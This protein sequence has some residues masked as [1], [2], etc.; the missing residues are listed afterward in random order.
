MGQFDKLTHDKLDILAA[1]QSSNSP[2]SVFG[3]VLVVQPTTVF[4][5][6]FIDTKLLHG[7]IERSSL[8]GTVT[9]LDQMV[10][11]NT[12]IT[13][14]ATAS[15]RAEKFLR[16]NPGKGSGWKGT[17]I[18][19]AGIANSLQYAGLATD[20]AAFIIGY[21]GTKFGIARQTAGRLEI[22]A[23]QITTKS[24]TAE[25]ITVTLDSVAFSVPVT[26]QTAGTASH[27]AAEIAEFNAYPGWVCTAVD[28]TIYFVKVI[29]GV[30]SGTYSLSG[31]T[32]AVG[33][34]TQ[35][36]A[37]A[38]TVYDWFYMENFIIE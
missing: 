12:G 35:N 29:T 13:A 4:E 5:E 31:A 16:Y 19:T 38:A 25:N 28:D 30:A 23:L 26:D 32:T 2:T 27:T 20:E 22:Q 36:Q 10:H 34:F 1:G 3:Q 24:T 33:A 21:D 8:G 18:F 17:P 7:I 9:L 6:S 15:I 37:G 11:V 14:N